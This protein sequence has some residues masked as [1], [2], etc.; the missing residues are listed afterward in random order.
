[1][2]GVTGPWLWAALT[3][4]FIL[5]YE[6]GWLVQSR[7]AGSARSVI[8]R[9]ARLREDWYAAVS[10]QPGSEVLAVQTLRNSVMSATVLASTAALALM[11]TVALFA[12]AAGGMGEGLA[13]RELLH[14]LLLGLLCASLVGSLFSVRL[15]NHAGFICAMPVGS[16]ARA[17]WS[18]AAV[19]HLREA[20]VLYG[21]GLRQMVL[22]VP[23]VVSLHH[24]LAGSLAAA[25]ASGGLLWLDRVRAA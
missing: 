4:A 8:G 23:V 14:L 22:V 6:L 5:L 3:T 7:R 9:H 1:M 24:G 15:Y 21:M 20:G 19:R 16:G 25:L 2:D 18:P 12:P 11:S 13:P 17:A 10:A